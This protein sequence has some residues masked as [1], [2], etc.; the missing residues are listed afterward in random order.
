MANEEIKN[1]VE[2]G[3]ENNQQKVAQDHIENPEMKRGE[4][5]A[6]PPVE[7]YT[8]VT[9]PVWVAKALGIG[10]K[11]F[12]YAIPVGI[13]AGSVFL[14]IQLGKNEEQ[15]HSSLA[16]NDL[17][18]KLDRANA[19][20]ALLEAKANSIPELPQIEAPELPE[21]PSLNLETGEF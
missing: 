13:A 15:K 20:I 8:Q 1:E 18:S 5:P 4:T 12:K 10:Q 7:K 17:Q 21:L 2:N 16:L 19:D 6:Q 3:T 11:I 9:M 14:G